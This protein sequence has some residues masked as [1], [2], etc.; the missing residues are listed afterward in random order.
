METTEKKCGKCDDG[1]V[2]IEVTESLKGISVLVKR[3]DKCKHAYGL[4]ET[5]ALQQKGEDK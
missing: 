5:Y 4:K 2:R 3:C 1:T